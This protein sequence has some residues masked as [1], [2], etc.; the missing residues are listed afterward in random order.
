MDEYL[1]GSPA[2]LVNL[3]EDLRSRLGSLGDDVQEKHLKYYIAFKQL[4]NFACVEV[5][6]TAKKLLVFVKVNPDTVQLEKDFTRDVRKIGHFG[7]GEL[8]ITIGSPAA[9]ERA[10]PFIEQSCEAS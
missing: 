3:Y 10:M 1:Q 4:R 2:D 6:P 9:L 5:H 7:T 8:E